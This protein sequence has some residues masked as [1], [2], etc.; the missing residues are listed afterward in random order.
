MSMPWY[1]MRSKP[2]KEMALWRELT[3]RGTECFYPRLHVRPVDPRN[4]KIKP[5]FPGYMFLRAN[6]EQMG[7]STLRWMPYSGGLVC[8][9]DLPATVPHHLIEAIGRH[10]DELNA[11]RGKEIDGLRRGAVVLI[12]GGPFEGYKA[13]FDARLPGRERVRV[14]L[15]LLQKRELSV[16]LPEAQIQRL[17]QH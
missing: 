1:V 3:A 6:L 15:K 7:M 9:D 12:E 8:F 13:I 10:V 5:Y 2:N 14:L 11:A 16:E 4:H 17:Q